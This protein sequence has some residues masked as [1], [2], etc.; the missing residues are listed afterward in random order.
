MMAKKYKKKVSRK[1]LKLIT[2]EK[3]NDLYIV[4]RMTYEEIAFYLKI[5]TGTVYKKIKQ[6]GLARQSN[7]KINL[8]QF[9][10]DIKNR[11]NIGQSSTAIAK[12]YNISQSY[13]ILYLKKHGVKI[14][15]SGK[16]QTASSL[17]ES[18]K[19]KIIEGRKLRQSIYKIC[20]Q[21]GISYKSLYDWLCKNNLNKLP[22]LLDEQDPKEISELYKS[23]LTINQIAEKFKVSYSHANHFLIKHKIKTKSRSLITDNQ[24][25]KV[26]ALQEQ[27]FSAMEISK[28]TKLSIS[29]I[30]RILAKRKD[31]GEL[32]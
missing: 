31:L 25:S 10:D 14:R 9:C 29:S 6:F 27:E 13:M 4:K 26:Y 16:R 22:N 8:D 19:D 23:G 18:F 5:S 30:Y 21:Y 32:M 28:K 20:K 17:I 24:L 15:K 2:A 1:K 7:P 11:Y 3:F 12:H